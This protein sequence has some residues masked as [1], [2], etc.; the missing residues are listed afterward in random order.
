MTKKSYNKLSEKLI[1]THNNT[2]TRGNLFSFRSLVRSWTPVTESEIYTVSNKGKETRKPLC[3]I[4]YNHNMAGVDLKDNL[5]HMY[6]VERKKMTKWYLKL[7]KRLLNSTVLNSCV[8]YRQV[9]GRN[10]QQLS[11]R[12]Q[13]V[14][15]LF[16]KYARSVE[17]WSVPGQQASDNT[18]PWLTERHFLRKVAPKTEKSKPQRRCVVCSKHRKKKTSVYYCQICDVGHCL[19]DRF[20]LYHMKL[21]Y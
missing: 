18:V 3:V 17:T 1:G 21:N 14:E 6:M 4:D 15:G 13:L 10:I 7:F 2:N 11:Y 16:T 20:E 8:V 9:T 12:F 19:E 5:L